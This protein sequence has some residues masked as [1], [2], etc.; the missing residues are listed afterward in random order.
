VTPPTSAIKPRDQFAKEFLQVNGFYAAR[1]GLQR[2]GGMVINGA[3]DVSAMA[4]WGYDLITGAT[5][6][7]VIK[8][9]RQSDEWK[10]KHPGEAP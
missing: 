6:K 2:P 3:C 9:I 7:D 4:Q 5:P 10:A 1:E 8:A